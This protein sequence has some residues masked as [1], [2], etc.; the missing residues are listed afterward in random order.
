MTTLTVGTGGGAT[1]RDD[2]IGISNMQDPARTGSRTVTVNLGGTFRQGDLL[3]L[4]G[5]ALSTTS[6]SD[7]RLGGHFVGRDGTFAGTD[8]TP[9]TVNGRTLT[10]SLPAGTATLVTLTP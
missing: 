4:T 8:K 9:I 6:T 2:F 1:L 10:L 5:P 7:I 3:R